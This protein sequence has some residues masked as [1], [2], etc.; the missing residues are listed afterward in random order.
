MNEKF[1]KN[2]FELNRLK[3]TASIKE[4]QL[5]DVIAERDRLK[6]RIEIV[7]EQLDRQREDAR[8]HANQLEHKFGEYE[9][10]ARA[11]EEQL[12][13][14]LRKAAENNKNLAF[15]EADKVGRLKQL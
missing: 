10:K 8:L 9:R 7:E 5:S 1:N 15:G 6:S 12:K 4:S 14:S 2:E 3:Q 13:E 11:T